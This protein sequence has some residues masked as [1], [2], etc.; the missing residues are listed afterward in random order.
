MRL[1]MIHASTFS[2]GKPFTNPINGLLQCFGKD[3]HMRFF[4]HGQVI[5]RNQMDLQTTL[6][7][8]TPERQAGIGRA[9]RLRGG[10]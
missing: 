7:Q 1:L 8:F 3:L 5:A 2:L 10:T 6:C 4:N 9:D